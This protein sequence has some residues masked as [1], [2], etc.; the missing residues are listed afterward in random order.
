MAIASWRDN[1]PMSYAGAQ[2]QGTG[3]N[4]VHALRSS[5]LPVGRVGYEPN[6][7]HGY[8][9]GT[10]SGTGLEG[11]EWD[12]EANDEPQMDLGFTEAHPNWD[13]RPPRATTQDEYVTIENMPPWGGFDYDGPQ[14][15]AMRSWKKAMGWREQHAQEIPAGIAA[16]GWENK[17]HGEEL[18]SRDSGTLQLY[19]QTSSQQRLKIQDNSRAVFRGTD[20]MRSEIAS[21][22]TGMKVKLF[23][24][25]DNNRHEDMYPYQIEY[26]PRGWRFRSVGTGDV[27]WMTPNEQRDQYPIRRDVPPDVW[28]GDTE[29][30][31]TEPDGYYSE[32]FY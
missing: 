30:T 7:P 5:V 1:L 4:P 20:E 28:Q 10:A 32:D 12:W 3:I 6:L 29:A 18:D 27:N 8:M 2:K 14:G 17:Q 25:P 16:E 13:E 24:P 19:M 23:T 11:F 21:R 22:Q 26:R 9:T 31:F 15:R